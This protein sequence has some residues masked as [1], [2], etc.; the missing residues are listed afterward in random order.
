MSLWPAYATT[1]IV[2]VKPSKMYVYCAAYVTKLCSCVDENR[3]IFANNQT[4]CSKST[5]SQNRRFGENAHTDRI[6]MCRG[7]V[8]ERVYPYV[9][10]GNARF[11][12]IA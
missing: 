2:V 5:F 3:L 10:D 4:L 11:S 12:R 8:N 7:D 1:N 9:H 6:F